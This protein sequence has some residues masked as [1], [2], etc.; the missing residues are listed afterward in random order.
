MYEGDQIK[1]WS[2]DDDVRAG[3]VNERAIK[4]AACARLATPSLIAL[5]SPV[6]QVVAN[7]RPAFHSA[8]SILAVSLQRLNPFVPASRT[9]L[10]SVIMYG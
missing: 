4:S 9:R 10:L 3:C 8:L 1:L 2:F 5:N 6:F 7:P